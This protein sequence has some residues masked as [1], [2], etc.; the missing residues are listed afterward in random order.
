MLP[1]NLTFLPPPGERSSNLPSAAGGFLNLGRNMAIPPFVLYGF[2]TSFRL[3]PRACA[4]SVS[5]RAASAA[6]SFNSR[7]SA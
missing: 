4:A 7:P 2:F 5:N 3:S 1:P 6:R